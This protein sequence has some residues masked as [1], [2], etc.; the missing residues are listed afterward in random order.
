MIFERLSLTVHYGQSG[1]V[2]VDEL[3]E[4]NGS[5]P[6]TLKKLEF[7]AVRHGQN[8]E[9]GKKSATMDRKRAI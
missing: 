9:T 1:G 2:R 3:N 8:R 4:L 6:E 5:G 7:D